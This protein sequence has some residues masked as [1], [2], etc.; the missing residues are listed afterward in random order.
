MY[1]ML[2][3]GPLHFHTFGLAFGAAVCVGWIAFE[4]YFKLHDL[5]VNMPLLG[6]CLVVAGFAGAKIDASLLSSLLLHHN[7]AIFAAQ[8]TDLSGGYTYLGC[9]IAGSI[10]G[11][12]YG[13]LNGISVVRGFD[14]TFCIGLGYSVGR[15]GC[16]LSGDGDYGIPSNLPWAISFPNGLVPTTVRVHPTMLYSSAWELLIFVVLWRLSRPSSQPPLRPG[17]LLALYLL[18]SGGGR[19]LVEFLSRNP[20]LAFG[21]T[22]AQFV[23][24]IMM[25]GGLLI[26]RQV[27]YRT[28]SGESINAGVVLSLESR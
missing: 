4:R 18:A 25:A 1:P 10:A 9:L 26:I 8:V 3:L 22:E 23:S 13:K 19:F 6:M 28:V 17:T 20:R 7:I 21:L 11:F 2:N 12:I 5:P 15:I 16:F 27:Y 14:S 24:A